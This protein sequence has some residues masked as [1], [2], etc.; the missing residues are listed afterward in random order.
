MPELPDVEIIKRALETQVLGK[1]IREIVIKDVRTINGTNEKALNK[2]S[3]GKK[4]SEFRRHGKYLFIS[5]NQTDWL[6]IF[7]AMTGNL[8]L[9]KDVY[10]TIR[11]ERVSFLL[12]ESERLAFTDQRVFGR[13]GLTTSP[14]DFIRTKKIGPDSLLVSWEEFYS[15]FSKQKT[16]IKKALMDQSKI[17]G[18]GNVYADEILFQSQISPF[19]IT[20]K[21]SETA[22]HLLYEKASSVLR[23]AIQFNADRNSFPDEY[24]VKQ[25]GKSSKCP[26]CGYEISTE[27]IT[28]RTTY[29][30][31]HC[32]KV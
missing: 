23:T 9:V 3:K 14:E 4:L 6:T 30:C 21:I 2:A 29:F 32:Q 15:I 13:I 27:K 26:R 7:F 22:L 12:S 10:Q 31:S 25:R 1:Q 28:G 17:S 5:L 20:S 16:E 11:F 18:I 8:L 24:I 19:S